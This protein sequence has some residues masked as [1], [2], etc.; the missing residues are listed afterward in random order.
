MPI[1][2]IPPVSVAAM[3]LPADPAE[4]SDDLTEETV[5][6]ILEEVELGYLA[7][8]PDI[9]TAETNWEEDSKSDRHFHLGL[10]VC[11][12]LAEREAPVISVSLGEKQRLAI[13][14]LIYHKPDFAVSA[15]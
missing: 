11:V 2:G 9:F 8:R 4:S 10:C 15:A 13:A 14:R 12:S 5:C 6:A 1:D 3:S 7:S